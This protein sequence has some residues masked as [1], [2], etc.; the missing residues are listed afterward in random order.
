MLAFPRHDQGDPRPLSELVLIPV[1]RGTKASFAQSPLDRRIETE[2]ARENDL[3]R[4]IVGSLHE[5][6]YMGGSH[7]VYVN[8]YTRDQASW[9]INSVLEQLNREPRFP[10]A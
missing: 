10:D 4:S 8:A 5:P 6:R 2:V 1:V 9:L 3:F 7:L